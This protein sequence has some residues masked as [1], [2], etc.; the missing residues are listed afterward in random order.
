[1][2][3]RS[4][5]F[6]FPPTGRR[7]QSLVELALIL[8]TFLLLALGTVDLGRAF[9]ESI[10]IHGAAEAGSMI[11]IDY[12]RNANSGGN[13]AV[14]DAIKASTNP[15]VFPFLQIQDSDISLN[16]QWQQDSAYSITVTRPFRLLTPFLGN[17][18][19]GNNTLTLQ[20][21]VRGRQNC[22]GG[23]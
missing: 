14:R 19:S 17:V 7:A 22:S 3:D 15:D 6:S 10:V 2:E 8:P 18:F 12:T 21:V 11:A 20:S 1:M 9:Y 13:A 4:L 23:C 16:V 5:S